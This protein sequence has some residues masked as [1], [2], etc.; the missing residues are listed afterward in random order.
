VTPGT[1]AASLAAAVLTGVVFG[2]YP[3]LRAAWLSPVDAIR[4]E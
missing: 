1:V 2:I 4:T 3:A